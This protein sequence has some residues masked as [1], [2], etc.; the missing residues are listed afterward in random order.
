MRCNT[1]NVNQ[2]QVK[3]KLAISSLLSS[4]ISTLVHRISTCYCT[5]DSAGQTRQRVTRRH[6]T[7]TA[8]GD[9]TTASGRTTMGSTTTARGRTVMGGTTTVMGDTTMARV[10]RAMGSTTTVTGG[11]TTRHDDGDALH[12]NGDGQQDDGRHNDG[13]RQ[14]SL[15]SFFALLSSLLSS[16]L[17]SLLLLLSPSSSSL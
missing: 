13:R 5:R 17:L 14:R 11:T 6:G 8:T 9:K 4:H 1:R 2:T 7:T 12:S 16:L 10:S 15:T 3:K